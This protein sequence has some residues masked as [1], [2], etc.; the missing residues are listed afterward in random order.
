[1]F[2]KL[3]ISLVAFAICSAVHCSEGVIGPMTLEMANG[4]KVSG[5][6]IDFNDSEWVM[7]IAGADRHIPRG[8]IKSSKPFVPTARS[9]AAP[10][11][12][13]A[14]PAPVKE[15][16]VDDTDKED[17]R[18]AQAKPAPIPLPKPE[19]AEKADAPKNPAENLMKMLRRPDLKPPADM[20]VPAQVADDPNAKKFKPAFDVALDLMQRRAYRE[21]GV[22]LRNFVTHGKPEE[23]AAAD[24][25]ARQRL[26]RSLAE[27]ITSCYFNDMCP[28]CKGEGV[29]VC[30]QCK[31]SGYCVDTICSEIRGPIMP[32]THT[33]ADGNV[34]A[35]LKDRDNLQR[36]R[37]VQVCELCRGNGYEPCSG[38][39]GT[40]LAVNE[41][42]PYERDTYTSQL[43][44]K[45]YD[46]LFANE[47]SYGDTPREVPP[48]FY[49]RGNANLRPMTE[50][51]WVRDSIDKVKSDLMRMLRAEGFITSA[52]NADPLLVI[53][54]TKDYQQELT[55]IRGRVRHLWGELSER[56]EVYASNRTEHLLDEARMADNWYGDTKPSP[57]PQEILRKPGRIIG[58][59]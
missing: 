53:R 3:I 52:M 50:Q 14:E 37:R 49:P 15:N 48:P 28:Q 51:I 33:T 43:L 13:K 34:F 38:C 58:D 2:Q 30:S 24:T 4:E 23:I 57:M 26:N 44:G 10:P 56:Y 1:M 45:A 8:D 20:R 27:V 22:L 5:V 35:T 39:Y 29:I 21:A 55:K 11:A 17:V 36:H 12:A 32:G 40:R 9:E 16:V 47:S 42:S 6:L 25:Q 19:A 46:C 54:S 41:P 31:G 7:R 59:E 18:I